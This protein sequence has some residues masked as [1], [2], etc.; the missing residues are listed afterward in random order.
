MQL[1]QVL[2]E[3]SLLIMQAPLDTLQRVFVLH[4]SAML[5]LQAE[6]KRLDAVCTLDFNHRPMLGKWERVWVKR[7]PLEI[8]CMLTQEQAG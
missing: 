2:D 1:Y 7:L 5:R 4:E 3:N 6:T 8:A